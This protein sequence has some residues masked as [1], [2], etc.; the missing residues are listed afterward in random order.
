MSLVPSYSSIRNTLDLSFS[1]KSDI[2]DINDDEI[3]DEFL[4]DMTVSR[5]NVA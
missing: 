5:L 3:S 4:L 1:I 2:D